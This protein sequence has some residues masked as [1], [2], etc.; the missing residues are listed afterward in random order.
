MAVVAFMDGGVFLID[1]LTQF[2]VFEIWL[3]F[4]MIFVSV[5]LF[6]CLLHQVM[7]ILAIKADLLSMPLQHALIIQGASC[8]KG[9]V[10]EN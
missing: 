7:Q 3:P 1:F 8:M 9:S 10:T 6:V 2:L 4:Q 5:C